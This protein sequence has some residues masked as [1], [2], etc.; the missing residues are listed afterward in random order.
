MRKINIKNVCNEVYKEAVSILDNGGL[1]IVPTRTNYNLIC[2]PTNKVAIEKVMKVKQRKKFGPLT[3]AIDSIKD[4]NQ[5]VESNETINFNFD[6]LKKLWPGELT[7][8]FNKKYPFPDILTM[9]ANTL[10]VANQGASVLNT[11]IKKY[12]KPV[13]CTSANISGQ[14]DIFVDLD[15]A[16]NDLGDKVDL[17]IAVQSCSPRFISLDGN[18]SNTIIDLT[19]EKPYLVRRGMYSVEKI[20]KLIPSLNENIDEYKVLLSRELKERNIIHE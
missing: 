8:I 19:F 13:G 10:A 6:I 12:G 11:L 9:G 16:K 5:Y 3:L 14:G 1:V 20:K 17:L 7:I 15:K 18:K 2:D 4:I